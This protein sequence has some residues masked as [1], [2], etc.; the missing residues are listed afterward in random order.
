MRKFNPPV[1]VDGAWVTV[2]HGGPMDGYKMGGDPLGKQERRVREKEEYRCIF[3]TQEAV[4]S[5]SERVQHKEVGGKE[6]IT[7]AAPPAPRRRDGGRERRGTERLSPERSSNFPHGGR[8]G[9]EEDPRAAR[10]PPTNKKRRPRALPSPPSPPQPHPGPT[11][12][13]QPV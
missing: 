11:A 13:P 3:L 12:L 8:K 10:A 4:T 9:G 2:I 5:P 7:M 6:A 1:W